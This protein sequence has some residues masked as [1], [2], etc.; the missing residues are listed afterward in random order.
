MAIAVLPAFLAALALADPVAGE[1]TLV[2]RVEGIGPG[3]G[4]VRAAVCSTGFDQAGCAIGASRLPGEAT[5]EFIFVGLDPGRYAVAVYF[6]AN[7]NGELDTALG[8]V[9][10]E[11]YA[12]SND[13]GRFAPPDFQRALVAVGPG[14]TVV[15]VRLRRLFGA[16]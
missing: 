3:K 9:P 8:G 13:V 6:D 2:V 4:E 11:P 15:T 1:A 16:S 12:F 5:E 14:R 7:G 10:T